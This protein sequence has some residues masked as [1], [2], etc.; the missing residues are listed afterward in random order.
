M[1]WIG[2]AG[3]A[4][5]VA[6]PGRYKISGGDMRRLVTEFKTCGGAA[7]EVVT[8]SHGPEQTR[9]YARLARDM[10]LAAS[11]GSDFHGLGESAVLPGKLPPL[12]A[13]VTPVWD[14][15]H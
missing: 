9:Q 3:G 15:R 8:C 12:P 7:L 11:R 10:G 13:G 6:H 4:A 5:V 1:H 14:L 2:A